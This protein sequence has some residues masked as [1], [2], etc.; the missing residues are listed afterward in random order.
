[1]WAMITP[2]G[3]SVDFTICISLRLNQIAALTFRGGGQK[4]ACWD[5]PQ[6]ILRAGHQKEQYRS[7]SNKRI[8]CWIRFA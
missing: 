1:M 4:M 3:R 8:Y 7:V 5:R 6:K 2:V